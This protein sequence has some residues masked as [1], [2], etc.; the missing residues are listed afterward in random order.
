VGGRVCC[1]RCKQQPQPES[2]CQQTGPQV[3]R[4]SCEASC[5]EQHELTRTADTALTFALQQP[6]A[7]IVLDGEHAA[8]FAGIG[9]SIA[10]EANGKIRKR[11]R[12]DN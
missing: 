7:S 4:A 5:C 12:A 3:G 1:E 9:S 11:R 2:A 8:H 10:S 6:L